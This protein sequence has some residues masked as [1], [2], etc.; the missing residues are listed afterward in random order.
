M[1]PPWSS[2][3]S[4]RVEGEDPLDTGDVQIANGMHARAGRLA[5]DA[6]VIDKRA[7]RLLDSLLEDEFLLKLE[8]EG[9]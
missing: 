2:P 1:A 6:Q 3:Q 8:A 9:D 4:W 7:A 5:L